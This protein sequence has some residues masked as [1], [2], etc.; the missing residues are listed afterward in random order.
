[1][2]QLAIRE[3]GGYHEPPRRNKTWRSA[4]AS[5]SAPLCGAVEDQRSTARLGHAPSLGTDRSPKAALHAALQDLATHWHPLGLWPRARRCRW[6]SSR[7]RTRLGALL[8]DT[9]LQQA[10][11]EKVLACTRGL[12]AAF[13]LALLLVLFTPPGSFCSFPSVSIRARLSRRLLLM[14]NCG[15]A[16]ESQPGLDAPGCAGAA[17]A[18]RTENTASIR[19][20]QEP[21][22]Q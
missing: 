20:S 10:V 14:S 13:A 16:R 21:W 9:L 1:M 18:S 8:R 12:C 6:S 5:W 4:L 15:S 3:R 17:T 19:V 11:N 22:W 7:A 2:S